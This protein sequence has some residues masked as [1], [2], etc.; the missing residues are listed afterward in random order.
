MNEISQ[1]LSTGLLGLIFWFL[2]DYLS[3]QRKHQAETETRMNEIED[4]YMDRFDEV[5]KH[6]SAID[7]KITEIGTQLKF[8]RGQ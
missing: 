8:D 6:L 5:N 1:W 2:K 3:E 7:V 4:N